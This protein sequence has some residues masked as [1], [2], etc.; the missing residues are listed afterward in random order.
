VVDPIVAVEYATTNYPFRPSVAK[1]IVLFTCTE[2]GGE[3]DYYQIQQALLTHNIQLHVMTT[4]MIQMGSG[5]SSASAGSGEQEQEWLGFSAS[6]MY[7]L[8]GERAA[9]RASLSVPHDSCTV[10]AQE[11]AGTV[12]SVHDE[13]SSVLTMPVS[14]IAA[15]TVAAFDASTCL[16]CECDAFELAPRTTCVTCE[17]PVPQSLAG[18][19]FFNVPYIK[20]RQTLKK[21]QQSLGAVDAWLM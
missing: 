16:M 10:L 7:T 15:K 6:A 21:A 11:V 19:S 17:V 9:D 1:V 20:L 5:A 12:W 2:C 4:Q 8:S 13:E 14:I 3:A 18:S